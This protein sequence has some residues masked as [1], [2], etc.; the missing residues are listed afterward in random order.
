MHLKGRDE[1]GLRKRQNARPLYLS[2]YKTKSQQ[3]GKKS[4]RDMMTFKFHMLF[5]MCY[6]GKLNRFKALEFEKEAREMLSSPA[7]LGLVYPFS[8]HLVRAQ[9][10]IRTTIFF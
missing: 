9:F 1:S 3:L 4:L 5:I 8:L 10:S 7:S 2:V 6:N